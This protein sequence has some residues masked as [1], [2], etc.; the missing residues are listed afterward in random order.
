[1]DFSQFS[2]FIFD[3]VDLWTN[4]INKKEYL[5]M[6]N[7][8]FE[9]VTVSNVEKK[10]NQ[11]TDAEEKEEEDVEEEGADDEIDVEEMRVEDDFRVNYNSI[12]VFLQ[13]MRSWRALETVEPIQRD[14]PFEKPKQEDLKKQESEAESSKETEREEESELDS[15]EEESG[16]EGLSEE[17]KK[18]EQQLKEAETEQEVAKPIKPVIEKHPYDLFLEALHGGTRICSVGTKKSLR[19]L[20]L[21]LEQVPKYKP[22]CV[23]VVGKPGTG[24][25]SLAVQ[26]AHRL[27]A[28]H[29]DVLQFIKDQVEK[30]NNLVRDEVFRILTQ[31]LSAVFGSCRRSSSRRQDCDGCPGATCTLSGSCFQGLCHRWIPQYSHPVRGLANLAFLV[32]S[33]LHNRPYNIQRGP[34]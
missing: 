29:I 26:L 28:V 32:H 22:P 11:D 16:T 3:V 1:M 19:T 2:A 31:L 23:L 10:Q 9:A 17:E 4:S 24:K 20:Q 5:R 25:T 30:K 14:L 13:R 12:E 21:S 34:S 27:K 8:L 15:E 6:L 33:G 18:E 7:N